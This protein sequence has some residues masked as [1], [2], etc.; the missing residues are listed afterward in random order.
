MSRAE[1]VRIA[2]VE[3]LVFRAP[4]AEPVETSFGTMQDRP[5]VLVRVTDSDGITGW[6]E[7]WCNFPACGAEHR[8]RLIHTVFAPLLIGLPCADPGGHWKNLTARTRVLAIQSGEAGP[9]AQAI[10]GIDVALWDMQARRA[11]VPLWRLLGGEVPEVKLYASG[12]NPTAPEKLAASRYTEG[13]RAFKLKI[14]FGRKLDLRNIAA[15]QEVI[16]PECPLM[17]DVNQGWDLHDAAAEL[18]VLSEYALG[19][20]EEPIAAD[21]PW[22]RPR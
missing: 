4:V 8:A 14:G 15:I 3:A 2:N 21:R 22:A 5:M 13:Y 19:W 11:G 16:G 9:F 6:G 18:G 7:V 17:V 20:I 10:A 12:L 1:N